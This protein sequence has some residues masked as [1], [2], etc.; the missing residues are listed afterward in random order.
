M[1][2]TILVTGA[3]GKQ[4]GAAMKKFLQDNTSNNYTLRALTRNPTSPA[5]LK[6]SSQGVQL[7]KGDLEDPESLKEALTGTDIAFLITTPDGPKKSESEVNQGKTFIDIAKST[8]LKYLVYTSVDGAERDSKVPH[9]ESKYII[10]QYLEASGIPHT[11]LRPVAF[12]DNF[13]TQ[14][15]FV[16]AMVFGLFTTALKG[17]KLQYIAVEDIGYAAAK[18]IE[19]S[20]TG[21]QRQQY[22]GKAIPLAGD[23]LTMTQVLDV[24]EKVLGYRP[25]Q[26]WIPNLMVSLMPYDFKMMFKFFEERGYTVNIGEVKE[27]NP[28]LLT[29]EKWLSKQVKKSE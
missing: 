4:G 23:N 11:I 1:S 21:E 16:T 8:N 20:T 5:S 19:S 3:T 10:E 22:Q 25:W 18:V 2:T 26:A 6:L 9:F 13:P 14:T 17:K 29:L 7:F 15:G 27:F 28:E 12:M 24:Y